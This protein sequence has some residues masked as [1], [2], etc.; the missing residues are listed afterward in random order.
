MQDDDG[1]AVL[2][3]CQDMLSDAEDVYDFALS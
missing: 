1:N 3:S 2:P